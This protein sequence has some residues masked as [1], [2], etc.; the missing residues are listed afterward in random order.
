MLRTTRNPTPPN[1]LRRV[2]LL[3]RIQTPL[4][5]RRTRFTPTR[6][7]Y[8]HM[9]PR[10]P[11]MPS[12][13]SRD[14][15]RAIVPAR[16]SLV[17]ADWPSAIRATSSSFISHLILPVSLPPFRILFVFALMSTRSLLNGAQGH[18]FHVCSIL[19]K[20]RF[21]GSKAHHRLSTPV[22]LVST[23]LS[24]V[25]YIL[26][27]YLPAPPSLTLLVSSSTPLSSLRLLRR[28]LAYSA[29]LDASLTSWTMR[30]GTT[31]SCQI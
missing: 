6:R 8:P 12:R 18:L 10:R 7:P 20:R 4:C 3:S 15:A 2:T 17:R 9:R 24:R 14:I 22:L 28:L 11:N 25:Q 23:L 21:G 5:N 19:Y 13:D 30:Y 29:P 26:L 16:V 27:D 1:N 31:R